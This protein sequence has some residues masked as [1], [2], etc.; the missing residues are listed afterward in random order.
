MAGIFGKIYNSTEAKFYLL[1]SAVIFLIPIFGFF[2]FFQTAIVEGTNTPFLISSHVVLYF[3]WIAFFALQAIL[4]ACGRLD[5]HMKLGRLGIPLMM[6]L[7]ISGLLVTFARFSIL[8]DQGQFEEA[9]YFLL[10]P[11]TDMILFPALVIAAISFR[12]KPEIHK[13]LMLL[14]TVMITVAGI[15]RIVYI[16]IPGANL[17]IWVFPILLAM[18]YDFYRK[19]IVHPVYI[20]GLILFTIVYLRTRL[21]PNSNLWQ[22]FANWMVEIFA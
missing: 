16:S 10:Q 7:V 1:V 15:V 8:V 14:A 11:L 13:R 3:A 18:V 6:I 19:R 4:P 22:D 2:P 17:L 5:L 12:R 20:F 9:K 21:L